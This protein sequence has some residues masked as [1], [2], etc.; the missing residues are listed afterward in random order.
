MFDLKKYSAMDAIDKKILTILQGNAKLGTKEIAS[1]IG[2]SIT[3]TYERIKKMESTGL[4]EK[5]VAILNGSAIEKNITVFCQISLSHHKKELI[6]KF[7]E[8][9]VILP[10]V[11][12]CF[13]VAGNSDF[14]LKVVVEDMN[15]F[16]QF[17]IEKLTS[18]EGVSNIQSS[19]VIEEIKNDTAYNLV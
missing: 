17:A 15:A 9:I 4:I 2:L 13:H 10:E 16:Q 6:E 12:G 3:P 11:M 8:A 1:Q 19:F 7:K 5:Y 18:F 14:L